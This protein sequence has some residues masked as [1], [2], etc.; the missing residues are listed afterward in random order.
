V[1]TNW[2][3]DSGTGNATI[4]QNLVSGLGVNSITTTINGAGTIKVVPSLNGCVG[5][6]QSLIVGIKP[7]PIDVSGVGPYVYC[8]GDI[9]SALSAT[10]MTGGIL[11]WYT[12]S[13]GGT[14]SNNAP[15]PS[16]AVG[17]VQNYY[18]SQIVNGKESDRSLITVTVNAAPS[19]VTAVVTQPT[20]LVNTGQI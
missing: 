10:P 5:I 2:T 16:T 3:I 6:A 1:P 11:Q 9:A 17:G 8:Q 19:A 12:V 15:V 14:P 18:V 7:P 20:C 13:T 4:T